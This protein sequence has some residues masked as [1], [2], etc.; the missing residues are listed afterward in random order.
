MGVKD[1]QK[2]RVSLRRYLKGGDRA[3]PCTIHRGQPK[4]KAQRRKPG[5]LRLP[6]S[7]RRYM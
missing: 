5:S 6:V 4:Q 2:L 3:P 7:L 1:N